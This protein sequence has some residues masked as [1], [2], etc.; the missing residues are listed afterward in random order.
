MYQG[1]LSAGVFLACVKMI[2]MVS[3]LSGDFS[4]EYV[5]CGEE[6]H[7]AGLSEKAGGDWQ[8]GE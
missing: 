1:A 4:E 7:E 3:G 2:D 8:H 6:V 5:E